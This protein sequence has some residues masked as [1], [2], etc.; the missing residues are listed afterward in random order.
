MKFKFVYILI[1]LLFFES[2]ARRGKPT[3]GE[4]DIASPIFIT[5]EPD[6]ESTQFNAEKIR[7][8]FNE[9]IKLKDVNK[10]LVISPPMDNQPLI[11]PIGT[12]SKTINIKITDTLKENTTYTF[13][14]GNSVEDNNEGNPLKS[15][16]YVFSTGDYIDS[17]T[18]GGLVTD[19]FERKPEENIS[20]QLYEVTENF[21]DSIIYNE[22]PSYVANTL[23]SVG[24][25]LTNIKE[26]KY[27][28][29]ALKDISNN[30][31]FDFKQDKIAFHS[32]FITL[33]SDENI[34][35]TLFQEEIPFVSTRPSEIKKG[36]LYFGYEGD[37]KG[38]Q[39]DLLSE[40]PSDFKSQLVFEKD[41]DTVSYWYTPI[42]KDSLVFQITNLDYKKKE[43]VRLR[44]KEIDSLLVKN[45]TGSVLSLR[46]T[47]LISTNIPISKIDRNRMS[48]IDK[49]STDIYF[50]TFLDNSSQRLRLEFD[51]KYNNRYQLKLFPK[52]IEDLFGNVN[53]TLSF[54]I[55]TKSEEDY[56]TLNLS[57]QNVNS[58]VIIELT[59]TDGT[60]IDKVFTSSNQTFKF[61]YLDPKKY[62]VK[63]IYDTNNNGKWDTGN[64]LK[65]TPPE[66]V[67][68]L[69]TEIELRAYWDINEIFTLE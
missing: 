34:S 40:K 6:H 21:T 59:E 62:L 29:I 61:E 12:A 51:K 17:L 52:A 3:G 30:Y 64:F 5:A 15:F 18:I 24:F 48:L 60:L 23:D 19:A 65:R 10:Q 41:K 53:D 56:G 27:L 38:I 49:D 45:E 26:G 69:N 47:L 39:I 32:S 63:A 36:H 42:A 33:P 7:L 9:F 20:I 8:N 28:M 25:E 67:F 46:D 55:S 16:K 68:Y 50:T 1:G 31:K 35:L 43:T 44:S 2:C 14:F 66:K 13:N 11:T 37:P 54:G 22:L 58:P 4:K 57:V